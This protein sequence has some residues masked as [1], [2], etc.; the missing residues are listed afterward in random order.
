MLYGRLQLKEASAVGSIRNLKRCIAW[1]L[2]VRTIDVMMGILV[3][4]YIFADI[5]PPV[6]WF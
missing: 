5:T 4:S 3:S 6:I 1:Q 2:Q